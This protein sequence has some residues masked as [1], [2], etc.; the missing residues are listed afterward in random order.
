MP[1][2]D[3]LQRRL[4]QQLLGEGVAH[5]DLRA[6]GLVVA[7]REFLR[8]EGCPVD[9]I[10]PRPGAHGHERVPDA[11]GGAP[12]QVLRAHEPKAHGVDDRVVLVATIEVHLAAGRRDAD[13]VAVVPDPLDHPRE[14]IADAGAVQVAEVEGVKG[15]DGARA[16]GED[17]AQDAADSRRGALVGLDGRGM[18]VGLDLEGKRPAAAHV[19]DA[20]VLA[21]PL[22]DPGGLGGEQ[23]Q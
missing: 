14:E 19:D 20:G 2:R 6:A 17:I 1:A 13:A 22:D 7:L 18:V 15:G 4:E 21:G 10:A 16:H 23:P 11:L 8:R 9:S 3:E 5:L 12:D